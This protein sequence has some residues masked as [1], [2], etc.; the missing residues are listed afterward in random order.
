MLGCYMYRFL[1]SVI[2]VIWGVYFFMIMMKVPFIIM[3]TQRARKKKLE[4]D[5]LDFEEENNDNERECV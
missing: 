2:I 1:A 3:R 4:N 5:V